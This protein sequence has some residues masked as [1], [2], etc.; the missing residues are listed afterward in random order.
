[1]NLEHIETYLAVIRLGG[2][3]DAAKQ[4]GISQPT[5]TQHI[6]KLEETVGSTLVVRDR[7]GCVPA[8]N[9]EAFIEH[10][11]ALVNLATK[12]RQALR[13]PKLTIGA[14]SNIGIYMLQ[15][16]FRRFS[17]LYGRR[18]ELGM[19]IERNDV[20]ARKLELGE[21][22][23]GIMEWWDSRPGFSAH[24]W[25]KEEM[26]VIVP[27]D[28]P[29]AGS[30]GISKTDLIGQTMIGGEAHTGTGRI[31]RQRLGDI[32]DQLTVSM[33]LGSTEAVKNAVRAGLGIS[34]VLASAVAEE[35]A[36]GHLAS[37]PLKDAKLSKDIFVIHR[38]GLPDDSFS[39]RFLDSIL[40]Q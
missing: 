28:H 38:K 24:C 23:V 13:R 26:V 2:F 7:A 31:L 30:T 37:I 35:A 12:A 29:W 21:I 22:D 8:P 18:L 16:H 4:L 1:M 33:N 6:K 34:V 14:A 32:C 36:A 9:T 25:R 19:L 17:E 20:I 39:V 5:V 10:A 15:P 11:Q 40:H 3:R 27:P